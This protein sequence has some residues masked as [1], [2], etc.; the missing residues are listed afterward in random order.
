[1][2]LISLTDNQAS[3]GRRFLDRLSR[4]GFP[5]AAAAWIKEYD[6]G[7][8]YLYVA[9]PFVRRRSCR[10][11][12]EITGLI[13]EAMPQP[14]HVGR[15]QVNLIRANTRLGLAILENAA[16]LPPGEGTPY[17]GFPLGDMSI[18]E[19]YIYSVISAAAH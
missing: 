1:M 19:A 3:D 16:R 5:L 15:F 11:G 9:T 14:F 6:V 7:Y 10:S 13:L 18:D 8:W 17:I 12:Y 2:E 4:E